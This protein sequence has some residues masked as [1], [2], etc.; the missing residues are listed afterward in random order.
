MKPSNVQV[1]SPTCSLPNEYV[2]T[3]PQTAS[4]APVRT[5]FQL[6]LHATDNPLQTLNK[7]LQIWE[8]D[9]DQRRPLR[10]GP[11]SHP[12]LLETITCLDRPKNFT[13]SPFLQSSSPFGLVRNPVK[14]IHTSTFG[15]LL[16]GAKCFGDDP[17]KDWLT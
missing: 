14:H 6:S 12:H 3:S 15:L 1:M 17:S 13:T 4:K 7:D 9:Q 5:P 10:L 11:V 2:R 16:S 8:A